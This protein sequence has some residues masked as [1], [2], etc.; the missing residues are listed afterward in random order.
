MRTIPLILLIAVPAL[1]AGD[2]PAPAP[3]VPAVARYQFLSAPLTAAGPA[4][5]QDLKMIL[6]LDTHTGR[7]WWMRA[8]SAPANSPDLFQWVEIQEAND[9]TT[10]N[11]HPA[12][13]NAQKPQQTHPSA[14]HPKSSFA[15]IGL[16]L[17]LAYSEL[18]TFVMSV[19][20]KT[21]V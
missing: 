13:S 21:C 8:T 17:L 7:T 10:S 4:T 19:T 20:S 16:P 2:T 5:D 6:R 18:L 11:L 15:K 14:Q 1:L 3:Q 9:P 12:P